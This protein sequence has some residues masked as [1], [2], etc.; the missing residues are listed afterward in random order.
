MSNEL[1]NLVWKVRL[2]PKQKLVLAR[3]ADR[4]N[5]NGRNIYLSIDTLVIETGLSRSSV[6]RALA[7]L[8]EA[9]LLS[10]DP[11]APP[12]N[13]TSRL[14]HVDA[15]RERASQSAKS[16]NTTS[17]NANGRSRR[18]KA[19]HL[20]RTAATGEG[21]NAEDA[22]EDLKETDKPSIK[23][24][25]LKVTGSGSRAG[26]VPC[27][28]E[29]QDGQSE[30][31]QRPAE[32]SECQAETNESRGDT[33]YIPYTSSK[34]PL[35]QGDRASAAEERPAVSAKAATLASSPAIE[36]KPAMPA[37][38]LSSAP[39]LEPEA[40]PKIAPTAKPAQQMVPIELPHEFAMQL[41][42]R[43]GD[44]PYRS[45]FEKSRV[46]AFDDLTATLV[47]SAPTKFAGNWIATK[48]DIS[49]LDAWNG[50]RRLHG[51]PRAERLEV[52]VIA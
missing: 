45:W 29:T 22:T 33:Q 13:T 8:D 9:G 32:T 21:D 39:P 50:S 28:P 16:R 42:K 6:F 5:D 30:T 31:E 38:A 41:K 19:R 48:F 46:I 49:V 4:A 23:G 10:D 20:S 14:I 27:Q 26:D 40:A 3:S 12:R 7:E 36:L 25:G 18:G 43:L 52:K 24:Q 44:V 17:R 15:L 2:P 35:I 47:L 11:D 37:M 51:Y 34:H 1:M